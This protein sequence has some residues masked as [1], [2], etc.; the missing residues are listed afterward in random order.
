VHMRA[1]LWFAHLADW[2]IGDGA[3]STS[4]SAALAANAR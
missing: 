1:D 2:T 4:A 3:D